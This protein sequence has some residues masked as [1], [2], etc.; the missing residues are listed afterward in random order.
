MTLFAGVLHLSAWD[1]HDFET[2]LATAGYVVV[3][4]CIG[5]RW[6]QWEV[7]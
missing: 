1:A 7:R 6:F 3:F 4:A 2:L 5:I